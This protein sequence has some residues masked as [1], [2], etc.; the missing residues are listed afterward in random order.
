M[1]LL[2]HHHPLPLFHLPLPPQHPTLL[3]LQQ[4]LQP[5][6]RALFLF[7]FCFAVDDGEFSFA[8]FL[9]GERGRVR[10]VGGGVVEELL[11]GERLGR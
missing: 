2:L 6:Q 10:V 1:R 3:L 9:E 8:D 7:L 5:L 11:A 4:V